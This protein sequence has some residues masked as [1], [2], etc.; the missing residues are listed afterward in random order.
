MRLILVFSYIFSFF[1]L[2]SSSDALFRDTPKPGRASAGS[3]RRKPQSSRQDDE[4]RNSTRQ[5]S[6][7]LGAP[8]FNKVRPAELKVFAATHFPRKGLAG[9]PKCQTAALEEGDALRFARISATEKCSDQPNRV[10]I[11]PLFAQWGSLTSNDVP[12][13]R[14]QS[15]SLGSSEAS[16]GVHPVVARPG[17]W[18]RQ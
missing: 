15:F 2:Q 6:K 13:D 17:P 11:G 18:M 14:Q 12:I 4:S 1:A 8:Q 3:L 16:R 5:V 10:G 7:K 9:I